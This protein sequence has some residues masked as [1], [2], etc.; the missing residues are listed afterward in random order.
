MQYTRK[1]FITLA[2]SAGAG[3]LLFGGLPARRASAHAGMPAYITNALENQTH[4]MFTE[5]FAWL[6]S[7]GVPGYLNEHSVP[8]SQKPW[9]ASE[10]QKWLTLFRPAHKP[11]E[12]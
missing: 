3:G 5:W 6:R 8:N 11:C 2:A 4:D 9:P 7:A 1:E 10:V 12:A